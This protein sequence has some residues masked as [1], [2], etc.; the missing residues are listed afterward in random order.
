MNEL[1]ADYKAQKIAL[2]G[3]GLETKKALVDLENDF[4]IIGILDGFREDGKLYGKRIISLDNAIKKGVKLIIVVARPGSCRAITKRIGGACSEY[5]IALMDIRG[6]NLLA[7]SKIVYDFSEVS[8]ITKAELRAQIQ[9]ADIVSFDLFDT[10]V[11]RQVLASDDVIRLVEYKLQ[12][13]GIFLKDFCKKRLESEKELSRNVSPTLTEIYKD[14]IRKIER[15]DAGGITAGY[16]AGLEF[17]TDLN[18]IIPR[19]DVCEIFLEACKNGKRVYIVSDTYYDRDQLIQILRKC[20]ITGYL[21]IIC[22]SKY[23]T[24]KM[25]EL[26]EVLKSKEQGKRFIHIGDDV[27]A[28]IESARK[29]G[30][31]ACRLMS[32]A[33]L[34]EAV[35]NLG[36]ADFMDSMAEHIKIGMFIAKIFNSPFQFEQDDRCIEIPDVY[37]IGY[38]ICAP[39]ISDFVI[40]FYEQVER[41]HFQN[42]WF[43]ARD[44]YLIKKMYAH[45]A[46]SFGKEDESEYFLTSRTAAVRAG[47]KSIDDIQHVD[48]MKFSGTLEESLRE[49]FGIESDDAAH[50]GIEDNE[51]GLLQY[52]KSIIRRAE[53]AHKNY[54]MYID[55]LNRKTGDVAFFD[56]VAKGTSQ[57]YIQRIVS[58]HLQGFYFMQLDAGDMKNDMLDVYSFYENEN[59]KT[60]AVFDNYYI[61]ETLLTAPHPSV[62]GFNEI[63]KPV[64]AMETRQEKDIWCFERAQEG[65]MD[66]FMTYIRL[67]PM[68]ARN[69]SRKLDE[70]FL[71]LV[72]KIR[73]TDIDF[74][75][76]VVEDPFFNRMTN[77][78]DI[79]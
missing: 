22:S 58:N 17:E 48:D 52:K 53:T 47:V 69:E 65:I 71:E 63:G 38:L 46:K 57:M 59:G 33:D 41:E 31:G 14:V 79:L 5:G 70:V 19:K 30:L 51:I 27:V 26:Y 36:F 43:S 73:M 4:E 42:I 68:R 44:G 1:F 21:E 54:K 35:G 6:K 55:S 39:I 37:D 49:R 50:E 2:Y 24:G 3:L 9:K 45:L 62:I 11:M 67:C 18:L 76:L 61:L 25:Q 34:L 32:A 40:W 56:F 13:K 15:A 29:H 60:C 16:L 12:E 74:L 28:D 8:G 77:I 23:E 7:E 20:N 78:T 64:Y 10:L 72:H 75:N 66:Y